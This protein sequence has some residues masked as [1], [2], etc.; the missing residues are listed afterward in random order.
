MAIQD[1][2]KYEK[3]RSSEVKEWMRSLRTFVDTGVTVDGERINLDHPP[4]MIIERIEGQKSTLPEVYMR[5][6]EKIR[7][8][9]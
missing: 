1:P 6:I 7:D 9:K 4:S 3:L 5:Q 8:S 2:A